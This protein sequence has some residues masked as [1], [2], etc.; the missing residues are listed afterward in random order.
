MVQRGGPPPDAAPAGDSPVGQASLP[1]VVTPEPGSGKGDRPGPKPSGR[2]TE[3][4]LPSRGPD[5]IDVNERKWSLKKAQLR[6]EAVKLGEA[7][8][9]DRNA[10][11]FGSRIDGDQK[12]AEG[13]EASQVA[14]PA[15]GEGEGDKEQTP[16]QK[17][18][19]ELRDIAKRDRE[20]R[21]LRKELRKIEGSRVSAEKKVEKLRELAKTNPRGVAAYIGIT[22]QQILESIRDHGEKPPEAVKLEDAAPA[23]VDDELVQERSKRQAAELRLAHHQTIT[24]TQ[25]I[26]EADEGSRWATVRALGN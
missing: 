17:E 26:V 15:E 7:F 21:R 6:D 24:A 19:A 23:R 25:Q 12:P 3:T 10:P 18:A 11:L 16:E 1:D 4:Y 5:A 20:N 8:K 13:D 14:T 22:D 9:V 2:I